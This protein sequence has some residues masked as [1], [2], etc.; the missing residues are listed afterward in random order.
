MRKRTFIWLALLAA[1]VGGCIPGGG[2]ADLAEQLARRDRQIEKLTA[3]KA[4]LQSWAAAREAQI[5]QLQ[6]LGPGRLGKLFH[7]DHI[8]LGR[9]TGGYTIDEAPGDDGIRVYLLPRDADGSVIKAAGEVTL[10]LF[11]L[12]EP[13]GANSLGEF[14]FPVGQIGKH[15]YGGVLT[16][17]FR[18]DCP[19]PNGPP[20]HPDVTIRATFVDTLTGKSFSVQKLCTVRLPP[21]PGPTP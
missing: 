4:A 9:H 19:W 14:H 15:W 21:P 18:F 13:A 3:E 10:Q 17:Y 5:L 1:T 20:K 7:V 6:A 8:D 2:D 16:Y 12:A 11:D